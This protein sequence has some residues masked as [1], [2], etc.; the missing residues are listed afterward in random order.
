MS[1]PRQ[2]FSKLEKYW[3]LNDVGNSAFILLTA[4]LLPIYFNYLAELGNLTSVQ[5]LSYWGYAISAV[6]ILV[7]ICGPVMG[8]I[9]DTNGYK[10]KLFCA[11]TL[12][13]AISCALLGFTANWIV[14]LCVFMISKF[15]VSMSM[16]FYDAMLNDITDIKNMD[17]VSTNGFAWGYIGS[18]IP[19][20]VGLVLVLGGD[21]V[22]LSIETSMMITFIIIAIWWVAMALPLVKNYKQI[23]HVEATDKIIQ[24]SF[25]RLA[26]TFK[27]IKKEKHIFMFL[28]SFFF[29]ID[30]V[31]TIIDMATAYGEA[32]G[33]NSNGL[34][35]ALLVTQIIAF[36]AS[37]GFS[38]LSKKMPTEMLIKI[39]I[40]GYTG[41]ACFAYFMNSQLHFWILAICVG[42]FQGGIQGMSRAYFAKII[43]ADKAGEYFGIFDI[44]GKGASFFG[45]ALVSVISQ[46][47]GNINIGVGAIG[48]FFVI[49]FILFSKT[50]NLVNERT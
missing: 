7:A 11:S 44:C 18:C 40:I 6:T 26:N 19:F 42:L 47:T 35:L 13:G 14:F 45:T 3:M 21:K 8:A 17:V 4:T 28:L 25:G 10:N 1:A 5:Y 32:L 33:L 34:L 41:I 15:G 2:K 12:L 36:P 29:Y 30:G 39:G 9:A 49:G 31:Y 16:I 50:A 20:C 37:I 24:K 27:E 46:L 38:I 48:I 43:P 22:G 23:N